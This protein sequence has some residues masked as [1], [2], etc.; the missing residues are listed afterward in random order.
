MKARTNSDL[1]HANK[2]AP[3]SPVWVVLGVIAVLVLFAIN[4]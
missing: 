3:L 1:D 2:M 4:L